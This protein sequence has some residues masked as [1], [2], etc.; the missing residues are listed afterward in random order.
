MYCNDY[1]HRIYCLRFG[2]NVS[3]CLSTAQTTTRCAAIAYKR[4]QKCGDGYV[5]DDGNMDGLDL[6][7]DWRWLR[8]LMMMLLTMLCQQ[9]VL[10]LKVF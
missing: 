4:E 2:Y 5:V 6:D 10:N 1:N 9:H 8:I 3:T 7:R